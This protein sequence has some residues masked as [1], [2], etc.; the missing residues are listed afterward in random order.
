MTCNDPRIPNLTSLTRMLTNNQRHSDVDLTSRV[1]L[2]KFDAVLEG[3][4]LPG[5][6]HKH[7]PM[8]VCIRY[9][10]SNGLSLSF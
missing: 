9:M 5:A 2:D 3:M 10:F 8:Y 6:G 4:I 7:W 1:R